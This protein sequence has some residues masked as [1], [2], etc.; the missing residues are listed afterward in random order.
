MPAVRYCSE[1][2]YQWW[3][4]RCGDLGCAAREGAGVGVKEGTW[5]GAD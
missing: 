3:R 4:N 5:Y 2:A 1:S